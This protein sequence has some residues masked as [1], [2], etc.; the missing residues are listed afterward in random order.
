[1]N[2]TSEFDKP[3]PVAW[4]SRTRLAGPAR[5][6][7]CYLLSEKNSALESSVRRQTPAPRPSWPGGA[8]AHAALRVTGTS[9]RKQ[10]RN[11][12]ADRGA[13][14]DLSG[15]PRGELEKAN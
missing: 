10:W 4:A 14:V 5:I 13:R 7:A 1:M 9:Q 12:P 8:D 2:E 15:K 6:T 3:T 11:P